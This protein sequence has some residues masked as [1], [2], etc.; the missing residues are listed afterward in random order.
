MT[1]DYTLPSLAR[2]ARVVSKSSEFETIKRYLYGNFDVF[3][4]Q[5]GIFITGHDYAGFTLDALINRLASGLHT[6]VEVGRDDHVPS[7]RVGEDVFAVVDNT[8][9]N[10]LEELDVSE[11]C[12]GC[13]RNH[14]ELADQDGVPEYLCPGCLFQYPIFTTVAE[15]AVFQ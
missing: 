10:L 8:T 4:A 11:Q 14:I 5:D 7:I 15:R 1:T 12:L 9:G 3:R 6:A 13:G 2:V